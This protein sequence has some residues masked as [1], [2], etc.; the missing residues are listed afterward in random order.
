MAN[1]RRVNKRA[2]HANMPTLIAQCSKV[3][4]RALPLYNGKGRLVDRTPLRSLR[5]P[6]QVLDVR[7]ADDFTMRVWPNDLIGRHIYLTGRF[8][9]CVVDALVG[10]VSPGAC[11]WDIGA[12]IGYVSCAFLAKVPASRVVAVEPLSDIARLLRHNLAQFGASRSD[13]VE[14]AV[15][16]SAGTGNIVRV[17]GNSGMSHVAAAGQGEAVRLVTAGTLAVHGLPDVI[18]IDVEGHEAAVLRGI[19]PVLASR[20]AV[21][22]V[23]EHHVGD[24]GVDPAIST[25]L[26]ELDYKLLRIWRRW[27]GWK[28]GPAGGDMAGG[29]EPSSDFAAIS[30]KAERRLAGG[31]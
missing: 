4:L 9:R 27:D 29:Y 7:T 16:D 3:F 30:R 6:E 8:D 5:F 26:A 22:V 28:L 25:L 21:L 13:V 12:N 17:T 10:A 1:L 31:N 15:S 24:R 20:P 19:A 18:K 2:K 23:F 14:A 11:L